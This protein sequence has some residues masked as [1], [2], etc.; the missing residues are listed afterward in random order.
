MAYAENIDGVWITKTPRQFRQEQNASI[1]DANL[2]AEGLFEVTVDPKPTTAG[3]IV[4]QGPIVEREGRPY[5]TWT[6]RNPTAEETE[7]ARSRKL[8]QA[9]EAYSRAMKPISDAYPIEEREGWFE[10]VQGAQAVKGGN[11]NPLVDALGANTG[12]T[13]TEIAD[14]IIALRDQYLTTYGNYT[15]IL[16]GLR[17]QINAATTLAELDSINIDASFGL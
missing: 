14:K 5:Q 9:Q 10:Q 13:S 8:R 4:E 17:G 7:Q 12:E 16:R 2:E 1:P 15:S 3:K 11:A 6:E